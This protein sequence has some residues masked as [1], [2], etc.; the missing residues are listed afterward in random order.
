MSVVTTVQKEIESLKNSIKSER[1]INRS[2]CI[3]GYEETGKS[4]DW[5]KRFQDWQECILR[6]QQTEEHPDQEQETDF[7]RQGSTEE[8]LCESSHQSAEEQKESLHIPT[9]GQRS[10]KECKDQIV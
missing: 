8:H 7:R 6:R 1:N 5:N 10:E 3:Q 4:D 2:K 9:E